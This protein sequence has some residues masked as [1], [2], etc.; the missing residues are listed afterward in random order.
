MK[1]R[2]LLI[3]GLALTPVPSLAKNDSKRRKTDSKNP[4]DT[5]AAI[6]VEKA[7]GPGGPVYLPI[8]Y[9]V[10]EHN[11][12]NTFI[13]VTFYME[14]PKPGEY[15]LTTSVKVTA[16]AEQGVLLSSQP[17]IVSPVTA[18]YYY[19]FFEIN[20]NNGGKQVSLTATEP[21][22]PG[23]HTGSQKSYTLVL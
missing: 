4:A 10:G 18:G 12:A 16:T 23:G 11:G 1:R 15:P 3:S 5:K 9:V 14:P 6:Q 22:V 19:V 13:A 7:G 17:Q 20:A 21:S 8:A 2:E